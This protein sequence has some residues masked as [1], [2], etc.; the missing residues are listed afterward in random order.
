MAEFDLQKQYDLL[1]A[2][3]DDLLKDESSLSQNE[4]WL[5]AIDE[6]ILQVKLWGNA[7]RAEDGTLQKA[8]LDK[9]FA[10]SIQQMLQE[11][12]DHLHYVEKISRKDEI[13]KIKPGL[14]YVMLRSKLC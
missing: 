9:Y 8:S 13:V 12:L 7:I 11:I 3:L 5:L 14:K 10:S 1:L 4:D 6:N 2:L